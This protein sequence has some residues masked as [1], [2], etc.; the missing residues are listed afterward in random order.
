MI[1]NTGE[2]RSAAILVELGYAWNGTKQ[3]GAL[4]NDLDKYGTGAYHSANSFNNLQGFTGDP[5]WHFLTVTEVYLYKDMKDIP[6][7]FQYLTTY[8]FSNE[9]PLIIKI[10]NN[11]TVDPQSGTLYIHLITS[12]NQ[13]ALST[14]VNV[15]AY[16]CGYTGTIERPVPYGWTDPKYEPF[17]LAWKWVPGLSWN[18]MDVTYIP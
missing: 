9:R 16:S 8:Y 6:L 13:I 14:Y 17:T 3:L 5:I 15:G 18:L 1:P 7:E 11:G 2:T 12:T 4:M 10:I